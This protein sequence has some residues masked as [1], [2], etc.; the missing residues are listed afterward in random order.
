MASSADKLVTIIAKI[1]HVGSGLLALL[2]SLSLIYMAVRQVNGDALRPQDLWVLGL[3]VAVTFEAIARFFR[4]A[5]DTSKIT[6]WSLTLMGCSCVVGGFA[7]RNGYIVALGG[8]MIVCSY[9]MTLVSPQ[10]AA[11]DPF[12]AKRS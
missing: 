10:G 12:A 8:A 9:I 5:R 3:L 6:I 11:S 7:Q 4:P 1:R 2:G